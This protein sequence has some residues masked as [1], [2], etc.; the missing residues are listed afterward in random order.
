[1]SLANHIKKKHFT[2]VMGDF[3][4]LQDMRNKNEQRVGQFGHGHKR[5]KS[6][7]N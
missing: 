5:T 2:V 4:A 6:N 7:S 3:N 1:M